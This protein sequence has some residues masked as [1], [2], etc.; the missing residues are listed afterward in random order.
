MT[1]KWFCLGTLPLALTSLVGC[2]AALHPERQ[3]PAARTTVNAVEE[4]SLSESA[5]ADDDCGLTAFPVSKST[6]E[7]LAA[8]PRDSARLPNSMMR[9]KVAIDTEGR[10]THLRVLCLAYPEVPNSAAINEQTIDS[11]KRWRYAPTTISGKPVAVCREV[12]VT[13]DWKD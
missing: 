7:I 5:S 12:G 6:Q 9:A 13:I 1:T 10:V 3:R 4:S 8:V 11:I 2:Q